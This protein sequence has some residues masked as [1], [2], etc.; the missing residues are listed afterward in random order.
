M[1]LEIRLTFGRIADIRNRTAACLVFHTIRP[2]LSLRACFPLSEYE[3]NIRFLP[4]QG[5]SDFTVLMTDKHVKPQFLGS[6]Q[7]SG[8][9]VVQ[10]KYIALFCHCTETRHF[11]DGRCVNRAVR[12]E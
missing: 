1:P 6:L 9:C 4:M 7:I 8:Y 10:K 2:E 12:G 5:L 3:T 11:I